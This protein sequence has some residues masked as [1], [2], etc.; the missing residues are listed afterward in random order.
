M[1]VPRNVARMM[2]QC[3]YA[4]AFLASP[5]WMVPGTAASKC[6]ALLATVVGMMFWAHF[7]ARPLDLQGQSRRSVC[8]FLLVAV[9]LMLCLSTPS[10]RLPVAYNG[11]EAMHAWRTARLYFGLTGGDSGI[12]TPPSQRWACRIVLYALFGI[13]VLRLRTLSR[14]ITAVGCDH[15]FVFASILILITSAIGFAFTLRASEP[16]VILRYPFVNK[17]MAVAPILVLLPERPPEWMYRI[18]PFT[19]AVLIAT[20]GALSIR[21][22][23]TLPRLLAIVLILS[24]PLVRY[25][26]SV[27]NLEMP[28]VL[29]MML[30]CLNANAMLGKA[31]GRSLGWTCLLIAG[32]IK[33]TT[34]PFLCS[35]V[36][37]DA[38]ATGIR[39]VGR[40]DRRA[41]L[42]WWRH[43]LSIGTLTLFPMMTYLAYR[44]FESGARPVMFTPGNLIDAESYRIT[45]DAIGTQL[46]G[47]LV[48]AIFGFVVL[49]RNRKFAW[50][51][52]L[53]VAAFSSMLLHIIDSPLYTGY[54]RFNLFV[55]PT[56]L[57]L[58]LIGLSACARRRALVVALGLFSV[59]LNFLA[60]PI[61]S[62]GARKPGWGTYRYDCSEE[63]FPFK[64]AM[65]WINTDAP[66][67]ASFFVAGMENE[68]PFELYLETPSPR[69]V[70]QARGV[71]GSSAWMAATFRQAKAEECEWILVVRR[72]ALG[73]PE[74]GSPDDYVHAATFTN[75]R[76]DSIDLYRTISRDG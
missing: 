56:V 30:V 55:L 31:P 19:S 16:S 9:G 47:L 51:L 53:I 45:I 26:G 50:L 37:V 18:L 76:S 43:V 52:F 23:S 44:Q 39:F 69:F 1:T 42:C 5:Y 15:P 3:M 62:A 22:Q 33:E 57:C 29:A 17:W 11:D 58:A 13:C 40:H 48:P 75:S 21:G 24:T 66:G 71:A 73:S 64:E 7:A 41:L 38:I 28:A 35:F 59:G 54:S 68:Y 10:M 20:C 46:A 49:L 63:Q 70:L 65:T 34:L 14:W 72:A 27:L 4:V 74:P 12:L 67:A 60:S 2:L 36:F 32:F 6:A 8:A 61:D 25:Y